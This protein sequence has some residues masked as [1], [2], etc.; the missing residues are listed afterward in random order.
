MNNNK[1]DELFKNLKNDFDVEN[2]KTGHE[3]RFFDKLNNKEKAIIKIKH[4]KKNIWKPL[5]GIAAS[6]VLIITIF[7]GSQQTHNTRDLASVSPK[8]AETQD[9]FN[10]TINEELQK[11]N[12]ESLPEVQNLIQDALKQINILENDY[13]TLKEDLIESGNDNRVI[14][15][16]ISNFQNRIDLLQNTIEQINNVKQLKNSSHE[17]STII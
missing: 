14:Y 3:T 10:T 16:M 12:K 5:L 2:P 17:T 13:N 6:I 1:I 7:I 8:M 9:F 15:A 11:L 4:S